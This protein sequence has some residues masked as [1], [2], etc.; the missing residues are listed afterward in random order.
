[1][2]VYSGQ[3]PA[4]TGTGEIT[5]YMVP[6]AN[7]TGAAVTEIRAPTG[8]PYRYI[9]NP[10]TLCNKTITVNATR[11]VIRAVDSFG[12][13][14]TDWAVAIAGQVY[15]GH[16]PGVPYNVTV[17][18]GFAKKILSIAAS[19]PSEALVV[20]IEN[21]YIVITYQQP[22]R[23]VHIIGNCTTSA[24]MPRRVELPSG[25]Y[26]VVADLGDRNLTYTI[27]LTPGQTAEL[28]IGQP[29][30]HPRRHGHHE[31]SGASGRGARAL[32]PACGHCGYGRRGDLHNPQRDSPPSTT[33]T[34][35]VT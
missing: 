23:G 13:V 22:T 1:M 9:F 34:W 14:R 21:A 6:M 24:T 32:R 29:P 30:R 17:D 10:W 2:T 35:P 18:A 31:S 20:T 8:E 26:T 33:N 28:V 19:H 11:L 12:T 5:L 15:G 3:T 27:T 16:T 4:A 7:Y 25:T